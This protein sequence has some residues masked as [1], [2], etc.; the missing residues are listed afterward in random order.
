[1]VTKL[2]QKHPVLGKYRRKYLHQVTGY[3]EGFLSRVATNKMSSP[4]NNMAGEEGFEPSHRD[5]ESR[6]LP[7]DDSPKTDAVQSKSGHLLAAANDIL[8]LN[9]PQKTAGIGQKI[10]SLLPNP[11][12][13]MIPPQALEINRPRPCLEPLCHERVEKL[14]LKYLP[15]HFTVPATPSY[16][17]MATVVSGPGLA[18]VC[19][20][21][22][23]TSNTPQYDTETSKGRSPTA[24]PDYE[25]EVAA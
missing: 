4:F 23:L 2:S 17:R 11:L 9:L 15:H 1:M 18:M 14:L 20:A 8:P 10:Q 5:P 13:P 22:V 12:R 25:V 3:S 7:L 19:L 21:L 6:V 16:N 24:L